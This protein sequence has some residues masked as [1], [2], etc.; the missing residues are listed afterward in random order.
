M[1]L[2]SLSLF[3]CLLIGTIEGVSQTRKQ[4]NSRPINAILWQKTHFAKGV[5]PPF[6]FDYG[7]KPSRQFIRNWRYTAT[8]VKANDANEQRYLYTYTEPTG[9]LKVECEVKT[10][11]DFNAVEWVLRFHN[12]GI[13]KL[14][15][16]FY[17]MFRLLT[18][19]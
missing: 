6:S 4:T 17:F 10:F 9:G 18:F 7:G 8:Q 19:G 16:A 1:K 12:M 14:S 2:K 11:A 5:L 15:V 3:L 13:R